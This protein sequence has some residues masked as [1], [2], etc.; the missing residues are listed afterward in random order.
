MMRKGGQ[1]AADSGGEQMA[2]SDDFLQ[3]L[4]DNLDIESVVSPYVDLRR[5]GRQFVGLCP[6]HN[7]KTPSFTVY[8]ESNSF[9][10]FGCNAGG[11]I[12]TFIRR[13][14]NLDFVE[15][16]KFLAQQAGM[17]LPEDG[18][19]D[20]LSKRR[21]RMLS[22]NRE[23]AR[24]FHACLMGEQGKKALSYLEGRGITEQVIKR[25]GLGYSPDSWD[26]LLIHM[27]EMG[28][29]ASELFEANL[30]RKSQKSGQEHFYD[31]F[32]NRIMIPIIDLRGNVVAFGGRI[33]DGGKIKY[34]NTSDTLVYK[35][36]HNVF[37]L[38]LAKN[39]NEGSLILAEGYMDVIALHRAGFV[40]AVACLGTALT[41]EQ[42]QLLSR[43]ASEIVLAYDTDTAGQEATKR[44]IM[45]LG[46]TGIKIRVLNLTG[47]K[48]PDEIINKYGPSRIQALLDGAV[49]ETEYKL[50]AVRSRFDL[51]SPDG[52][53]GYLNEA[54][55]VLAL[56][57]SAVELDIYATELSN[58]LEVAKEAILVQVKTQSGKLKKE[59]SKEREK[60]LFK[61]AKKELQRSGPV[62]KGPT[63]LS[64]KEIMAEELIVSILLENPDYYDKF[65][66]RLLPELF[67]NELF[68]RLY[69]VLS[70]R[71]EE[72]RPIDLTFLS[73]HF[74]NDEMT[75]ITRLM[76]KGKE[77]SNPLDQYADC[78]RVLEK[79]AMKDEKPD[80]SQ[81]SD[82]EYLKLFKKNNQ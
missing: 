20:T 59:K 60:E 31:S 39:K 6:F 58:E 17:Q 29:S 26:G 46:Q 35:K 37:A 3:S 1:N 24:F 10:C 76:K 19:D 13:I 77:L 68:K 14:E 5:R 62:S 53:L 69:G 52:R 61:E 38:N 64:G 74:S 33:L 36:S 75:V 57:N 21:Q 2:I 55:K 70:K 23:A 81:L 34:I 80:L 41:R 72:D 48:D 79:A 45:V 63:K 25:F 32:V 56:L 12:V 9:F 28:Y 50:S 16:V 42:A 43:Y 22:A 18:Y 8:P 65:S 11:E 71:I 82:E 7:E 4:R 44:A 66:K 78:V 49:N 54:I 51:N 67:S 15:A 47:G 27:R 40:N 73:Q 30:I